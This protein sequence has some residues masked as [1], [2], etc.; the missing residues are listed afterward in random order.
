[1]F[2]TRVFKG[3]GRKHIIWKL[4][5][6]QNWKTLA[7]GLPKKESEHSFGKYSPHINCVRFDPPKDI[8]EVRAILDGTIM[9]ADEHIIC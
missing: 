5:I 2:K 6:S 4:L 1:M 3:Y 8:N 7:V 9:K